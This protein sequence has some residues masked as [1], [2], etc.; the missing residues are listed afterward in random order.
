MTL[1]VRL[2]LL[3]RGKMLAWFRLAGDR[4]WCAQPQAAMLWCAACYTVGGSYC[5]AKTK[6]YLRK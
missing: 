2:L 3:E 6:R 1:L 5:E 4:R